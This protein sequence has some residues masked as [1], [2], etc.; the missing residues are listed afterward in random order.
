MTTLVGR[1]E[2]F[3]T[4]INITLEQQQLTAHIVYKIDPLPPQTLVLV[5]IDES[6]FG[7]RTL[8]GE[9]RSNMVFVTEA[10]EASPNYIFNGG[11]LNAC[12]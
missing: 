1:Y 9:R 12:C 11:R 10:G 3:D 7:T 2:S 5:P 8:E 4:I 6:C